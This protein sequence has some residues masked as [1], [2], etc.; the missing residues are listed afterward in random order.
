MKKPF[1]SEDELENM[2]WALIGLTVFIL[3]LITYA[4]YLIFSK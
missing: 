2:F 4:V 1:M 3:G